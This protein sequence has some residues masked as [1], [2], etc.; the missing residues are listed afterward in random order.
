[1]ADTNVTND[2]TPDAATQA[3]QRKQETTL[4]YLYPSL[5]FGGGAWKAY[6]STYLPMLYTDIYMLPV[7]LSGFLEM[8]QQALAWIAA[9]V[10]GTVLD[11][12]TTKK[13]KYWMWIL[14]AAVL[15][16]GFYIILFAMPALSSNPASMAFFAFL[17]AALLALSIAIVDNT[18][19][20]LFP[21]LVS[22]AADRTFLS[23]GRSV[24]RE[25]SKTI[26]GALTPIMLIYFTGAG[27][28]D[29]NGW[30][31]TAVIV[32]ISGLIFYVAFAF[33]LKNSYV[34]RQ[35]I[36]ETG[37]AKTAKGGKPSLTEVFKNLVT[38]RPLLVMFLYFLIL[39]LYDLGFAV[40]TS[41]YFFRY[42]IG[43]MGAMAGY[44]TFR[45]F[46]EL[47]G[48][49]AGVYWLKI[50]KDSKRAFTVS[51]LLHIATLV[52]VVF[53]IRGLP[54][55]GII[56]LLTINQFFVGLLSAYVLPFFA[57]ASDYG[58][59]RTGTR[60]DGLNMSTYV[61]A[62]RVAVV[63]ATSF[64]VGVLARV[65]YDAKAY[66]AGAAPSAAVL[67][68][69]L[70]FQ[71]LYPLIL[72]ILGVALVFFLFPINDAKL[73]EIKEELKAKGI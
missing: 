44:M 16:A 48:S 25:A 39:K 14:L 29:V 70:N 35:A 1:M 22:S 26:F 40:M 32:G 64:R 20:A 51:G 17:L 15:A 55:T 56:A 73:K 71:S 58:A 60:T 41:A 66:A 28:S 54:L 42:Y 69:L 2:V 4:K 23:A 46:A 24:G 33:Y 36:A 61:L 10:W 65:G 13:G 30:A 9:P 8:V 3:K 18:G 5:D 34:E 27:G 68:Q 49:V 11:R 67:N 19:T 7:V 53:T 47:A 45:T 38:N 31:L 59:L 43:N 63:I 57:A 50:M 72:S 37:M 62:L 52:V 6:F 12:V 21:R